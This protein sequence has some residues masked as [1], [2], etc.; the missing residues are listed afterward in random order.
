[1]GSELP[2][3]HF[4]TPLA[5]TLPAAAPGTLMHPVLVLVLCVVAGVGTL[6]ALPGRRETSW[7]RI[8]GVI[9]LA[10]V[11]IFGALLAHHLADEARGGM[12]P[13]FWIFSFLAV[14]GAFRVVT[15][16]RPVYSALYF[17]LTVMAS[18]GLFVLLW[19]D[20]MAAALV[21]IYAGAILVTYVFVIMLASQA[22]MPTTGKGNMGSLAAVTDY[23]T[24]SRDPLV[25]SLIG[26]ALM[27]VLLF[28]ILDKSS[29]AIAPSAAPAKMT[30]SYDNSVQALGH[31]LMTDQLVNL[32]LAGLILTIAMMGAIVIARRRIVTTESGP[33]LLETPAAEIIAGLGIEQTGGSEPDSIPVYGT[34][35]AAAKA[36]PER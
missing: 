15:H 23:D 8:G 27:G 17:V 22:Q 20:F 9:A 4:N 3:L 30:V 2:I 12:G 35:N 7:A 32:E 11:I 5:L 25:A 36:Y 1:M 14:F 34:D 33:V 24:V 28:V 29:E 13:Y 6:L 16:P 19:A 21:V 18:A 10:A 31:Y 26:F